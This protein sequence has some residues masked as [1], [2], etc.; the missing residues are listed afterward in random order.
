MDTQHSPDTRH[1]PDDMRPVLD[2]QDIARVLTRIAHEIVERAKGADDVVLLGIPTR[3]VYLARRLAAKLEE[4]TGTKI[5]VGSLDITMYRDDLR[6]KPARAIGRTE[7]PDDDID[8]RL[9]VLVD[10]VLF[11]GRTIRAALDAL[12][13]I[14]RPRAVQL[15]V[16]VDRGHRELPIRADYVGKNLPTSLRE[17]VKV[18]LQEEDGRDAVL[19]GQRTAPAA[20]QQ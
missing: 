17:T 4:I 12:G 15:A 13:A 18:Q 7:I 20:G 2:A 8:G 11:S 19:L 16:L 14:G 3:G 6:L 9:V 10:D 5:P 1:S